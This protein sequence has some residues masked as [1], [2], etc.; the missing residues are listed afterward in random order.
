MR[1]C[2][3]LTDEAARHPFRASLPPHVCAVEDGKAAT[4][5]GWRVTLA[6][7]RG[8]ASAYVACVVGIVAFI[9]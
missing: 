7:M 3:V 5:S 6:D 4:Q 1:R 8:F 9:A 2:L